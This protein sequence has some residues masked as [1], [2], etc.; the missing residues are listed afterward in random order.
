MIN[1]KNRN[2]MIK[3]K[4]INHG[5][6]YKFFLKSIDNINFLVYNLLER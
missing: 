2:T 5:I 1:I 3:L 6:F 4:K